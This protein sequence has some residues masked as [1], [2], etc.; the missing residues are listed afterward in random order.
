MKSIKGARSASNIPLT[1]SKEQHH[2]S[3]VLLES[4]LKTNNPGR[5]VFRNSLA[6]EAVH[7]L[8]AMQP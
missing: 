6:V 4:F 3:P 5:I 2:L 8:V 1:V 7:A